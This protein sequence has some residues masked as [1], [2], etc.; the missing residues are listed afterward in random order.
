M[1]IVVFCYGNNAYL[2]DT[3]M[4]LKFTKYEKLLANRFYLL[5]YIDF[6]FERCIVVNEKL[7][8]PD[9]NCVANG[10]SPTW[11]H[12]PILLVSKIKFWTQKRSQKIVFECLLHLER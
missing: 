6:F 10:R 1:N 5:S 8:I 12:F 7:F 3:E 9:S 4:E 11:K 2:K